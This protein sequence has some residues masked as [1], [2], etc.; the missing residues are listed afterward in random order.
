MPFFIRRAPVASVLA[1]VL[2]ASASLAGCAQAPSSLAGPSD[3]AFV[4]VHGAFEDH[5]IWDTVAA[6]LRRAGRQVVVVDLPGRAGGGDA[7]DALTLDRYRDALE[8]RVSALSGPAVLVGHSFGGIT[9]SN[10]AEQH[11]EQ[12][13][14]LVYLGALLPRDGDSA[15]TLSHADHAN[16]IAPGSLVLSADHRWGRMLPSDAVARLALFCADCDAAQAARFQGS[17]VAEPIEPL[18]TPVHLSAERY[19]RV[20]KVYLATDQD[21]VISPPAQ[22]AM[23]AATPVRQVQHLATSHSPF[24]SRPDAVV[25]A[26]LHLDDRSRHDHP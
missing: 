12:V 11:P 14:T 26:L 24:L 21:R 19:G 22:Q 3:A 20:D 7:D 17:L 15:L 4:L 6:G 1:T 25:Q 16:G 13:R 5:A 10:L 23:L 8:A 9:I 18:R 2:V